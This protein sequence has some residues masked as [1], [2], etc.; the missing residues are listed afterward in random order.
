MRNALLAL[1][2]EQPAH[3][4]DLKGRLETEFGAAWPSVNI[5]QVYATLGRLERD[6]LVES[7]SVA[8]EGRPEKRVY[9][10]TQAGR[11]VLH[12]WLKSPV[13]APR[14]NDDIFMKLLLAGLP[15][16]AETVDRRE[17][18]Q[19]LRASWLQLLRDANARALEGDPASADTLLLEGA[20]LHLQADIKW[21]ELYELQLP[22]E[23]KQ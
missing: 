23:G 4:Y 8:Q 19:T 7:E 11:D 2:A 15:G 14:L 5:G 1:L 13:E 18:V 12:R 3:G 17:M 16:L 9:A 22:V 10:T 20:I 21:L 6:G